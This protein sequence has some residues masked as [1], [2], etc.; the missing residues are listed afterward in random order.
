MIRIITSRKRPDAVIP[1]K[2]ALR[3]PHWFENLNFG[4]HAADMGEQRKISAK[5]PLQ[6]HAKQ[7]QPT[8]RIALLK[9][10]VSNTRRYK[11]KIEIFTAVMVRQYAII[12]GIMY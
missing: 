11:S 5:T 4:S 3:F 10:T 7:K 12:A 2:K 9:M 6:S 8:T 1:M